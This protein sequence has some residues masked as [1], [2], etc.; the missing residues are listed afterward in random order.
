ME[1]LDEFDI[2]RGFK[3]YDAYKTTVENSKRETEFVKVLRFYNE[4]HVMIDIYV[5]EGEFHIQEP[6]AINDDFEPIK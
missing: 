1:H 2:L 4:R 5:I 6:Y 3:F